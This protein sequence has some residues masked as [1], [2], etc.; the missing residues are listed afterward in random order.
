MLR[1]A[2]KLTAEILV[3]LSIKLVVLQSTYSVEYSHPGCQEPLGESSND[4]RLAANRL[5]HGG[6][7]VTRSAAESSCPQFCNTP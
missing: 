5:A 7:L 2:K 6:N 4:K 1:T 3:R